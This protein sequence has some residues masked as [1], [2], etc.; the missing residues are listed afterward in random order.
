[1]EAECAFI[2]FED[3]LDKLE[4]LVVDVVDKVL[5]SPVGHLVHELNPDFQVHLYFYHI[6]KDTS[7]YWFPLNVN[8]VI[9]IYCGKNI[10]SVYSISDLRPKFII[11]L[12]P[13][14]P[15][16]HISVQI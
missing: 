12:K 14:L 5:A 2:T 4:D 16:R 3:L 9:L 10:R 1:V 11:N 15:I 13:F 7:H 8:P 6:H